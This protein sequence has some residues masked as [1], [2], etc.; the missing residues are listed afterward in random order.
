MY[1]HRSPLFTGYLLDFA[2]V[3]DRYIRDATIDC[4]VSR[5]RLLVN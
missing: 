3:G 5:R 2:I 1:V 4:F